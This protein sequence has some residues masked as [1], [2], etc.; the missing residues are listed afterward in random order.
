MGSDPRTD[1]T[2]V[3][4]AALE[5]GRWLLDLTSLYTRARRARKLPYVYVAPT[6]IVMLAIIAVP[7]GKAV[8]MS[9][10]DYRLLSFEA[11]PFTGIDNYRYLITEDLRF[12]RVLLNTTY[13][14]VVGVIL[15]YVL[16]MAIALLL[17]HRLLRFKQFFRGIVLVPW[18]IPTA[19]AAMV[20]QT[21]FDTSY[22][23][24]NVTLRNIGFTDLR[25]SWLGEPDLVMPSLILVSLWKFC[26]FF[27]IGLLAG[28]QAVSEEFYESAKV[29]GAGAW[30]RFR[31]I[32]FPQLMPISTVL[33]VL[34]TIWRANNF[35]IVWLLTKG[36]P[37]DTTLLV[38]P[39]SYLTAITLSKPGMASA[40]S[41]V[42]A[43]IVLVVTLN[44]VRKMA[45]GRL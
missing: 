13:W 38:A 2:A 17:N 29:D 1:N 21:F 3:D 39:Y 5:R 44:V 22:G 41:V 43:I 18:V 24:F 7:L 11:P 25:I 20:F 16:A 34:G 45:A 19:V 26:P 12:R 36:G 32:A 14:T 4:P 23:L 31:Y 40:I 33:I 15:N 35:D 8:H 9:L 42:A 30:A 28:L 10:H 37:G 27:I 6:V